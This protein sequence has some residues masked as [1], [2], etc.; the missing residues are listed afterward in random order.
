MNA[1]P[2]RV[3]R[4][5]VLMAG[6]SVPD[7]TW[8]S[9]C[10]ADNY[11]FVAGVDE[12][13]RGAL[14]GPIIAAA[15]VFAHSSPMTADLAMIDDSKVLSRARRTE[16]A[17]LIRT[18]ALAW[19]IGSVEAIV[20]DEIG[21]AR[22]N[23]LAM[24]QA[25]NGLHCQSDFILL[26]ALTCE[27]GLP[28]SGLI[29]GDAISLSI[30]AASIIAKTERD[31]IMYRAHETDTRYGFDRHVGYGT[32]AHLQALREHGPLP[33]HRRTFRGVLGEKI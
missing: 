28:Q 12:A 11:Q 18:T 15:V 20:I 29:D 31:A 27:L 32:R 8:E 3:S 2:S 7:F 17:E 4:F 13:G 22:A 6:N 30:A 24:E 10:W 1:T 23:R 26:D 14:A 5:Y 16:L 9:H 33:I 21:I 25:I 19:A